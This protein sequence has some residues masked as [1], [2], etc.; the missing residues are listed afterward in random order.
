MTYTNIAQSSAW[1][2][3]K[4]AGTRYQIEDLLR[5]L[6]GFGCRNAI[7]PLLFG[8]FLRLLDDVA[9]Q[10]HDEIRLIEQIEAIECRHQALRKNRCLRVAKKP[11]ATLPNVVVN[12]VDASGYGMLKLVVMWHIF[13]TSNKP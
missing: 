11:D 6:K 8:K 1:Y 3:A 5:R 12:D 10:K 4:L 13:A 9:A 2:A 7:K